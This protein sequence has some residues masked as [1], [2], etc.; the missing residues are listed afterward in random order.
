MTFII[1]FQVH[2][3]TRE[4]V[5][6]VAVLATLEVQTI[7]KAIVTAQAMAAIARS[8]ATTAEHLE[9]LRGVLLS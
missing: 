6:M 8:T 9:V 3:I 5:I 1:A 4:P 7:I 2:F